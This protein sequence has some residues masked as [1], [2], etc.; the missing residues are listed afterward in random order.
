MERTYEKYLP[1]ATHVFVYVPGSNA[2]KRAGSHTLYAASGT[3]GDKMTTYT[4]P[5]KQLRLGHMRTVNDRNTFSYKIPRKGQIT[6][7]EAALLPVGGSIMRVGKPNTCL[8][9]LN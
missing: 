1:T 2:T 9:I 6:S 5:V 4:V 7:K 8:L 3:W